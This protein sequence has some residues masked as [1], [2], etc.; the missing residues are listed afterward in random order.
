ML[1]PQ[2]THSALDSKS[3][4][5][6]LYSTPHYVQPEGK[7]WKLITEVVH[8]GYSEG[9]F[10]ISL[11]GEWISLTPLSKKDLV[12]HIKSVMSEGHHFG[13]LI[14]KGILADSLGWRIEHSN[15]VTQ[16]SEGEWLLREISG[17]KLG[18][19]LKDWVRRFGKECSIN[20][21][22]V[23][24]DLSKEKT[25]GKDIDLDPYTVIALKDIWAIMEA[26]EHA[27][28]EADTVYTSGT[29]LLVQ[30]YDFTFDLT[31]KRGCLRFDTSLYRG[32]TSAV[33]WGYEVVTGTEE[34]IEVIYCAKCDFDSD[35]EAVGNYSAVL[36]GFIAEAEGSTVDR[37]SEPDGTGYGTR[38]MT[39]TFEA[40]SS[41]DIGFVHEDD[42]PDAPPTEVNDAAIHVPNGGVF[43]PYLLITMP[44]ILRHRY[45]DG[46]VDRFR[47]ENLS[48]QYYKI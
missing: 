33:L 14:D 46:V 7:E 27:K 28:A 17:V 24:L 16:I 9:R 4:K 30:A 21:E 10:V 1:I 20:N 25:I 44:D 5:T 31:F 8:I 43:D 45:N 29:S 38:D 15:K 37:F 48:G 34:G 42:T 39:P 18:L 6:R 47:R 35:I 23:T 12:P 26:D 19:T 3:Q 41:F 11:D 13:Y 2:T 40:S 36:T 32:A 22:L